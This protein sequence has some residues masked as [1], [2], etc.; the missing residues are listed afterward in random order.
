MTKNEIEIH[1]LKLGQSSIDFDL[2]LTELAALKTIAVAYN[3]QDE[4]KQIWILEQIVK[5]NNLYS[6][7]FS[8]LKSKSYYD[9]W[10]KLEQIEI[11]FLNLKKHFSYDYEK[12]KLHFIEKSVTNLQTIFPYQLFFSSEILEIEKK[13]NICNQV[14]TIRKSCGHKTGEIYNGELCIRIISKS[15]L[16]GISVVENPVHKYS[17]AFTGNSET[18]ETIDQY[19]YASVDYLME[20]V[21]S[22]YE[23]WDLEVQYQ[24]LPHNRF[25]AYG[26]NDLCPCG[27]REKYKKCCLTK[28]GVKFLNH[29]FIVEKPSDKKII[30]NI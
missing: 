8:L 4:A 5:I 3:N 26:K 25:K 29:E 15:E 6:T 30:T 28:S 12:Y 9:A 19:N 20:L 13:C 7:V 16:L 1:L 21:H 11:K 14:L 24:L 10:C 23:E 2:L 17:V 27:S 18:D 22:P